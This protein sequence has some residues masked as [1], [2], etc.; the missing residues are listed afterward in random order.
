M[1]YMI[2]IIG[3]ELVLRRPGGSFYPPYWLMST[4]CHEVYDPLI[5]CFQPRL[6]H[7]LIP[8]GAHQGGFILAQMKT[9]IC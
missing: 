6:M 3:S 4:L 9:A 2:F 8:A 7:Y 5:S 1:F